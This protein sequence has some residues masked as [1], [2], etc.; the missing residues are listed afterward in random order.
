MDGL[1]DLVFRAGAAGFS[2]QAPG[3][4]EGNAGLL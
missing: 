3:R 4:V 1:F 2:L